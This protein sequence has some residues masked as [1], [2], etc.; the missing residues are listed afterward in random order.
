MCSKTI[1]SENVERGQEYL[2]KT[3]VAIF[4]APSSG[5][6]E[7]GWRQLFDYAKE[8]KKYVSPRYFAPKCHNIRIKIK[9]KN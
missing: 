4:F 6:S 7:I 3:K 1:T 5:S 2:A 9:L 8:N